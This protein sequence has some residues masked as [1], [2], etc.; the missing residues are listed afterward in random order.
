MSVFNKK[1]W[2][3]ENRLAQ[4]V[5]RKEYARTEKGRRQL[6][7]AARTAWDNEGFR[8]R[9]S[10]QRKD[11][12]ASEKGQSHMKAMN[13]ASQS[14]ASKSLRRSAISK[15]VIGENKSTGETLTFPSIT[16]A[17]MAMNVSIASISDAIK[18]CGSSCGY[19]WRLA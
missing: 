15:K 7:D 12:C 11:Y 16:A 9:K 10:Q 1:Y 17:A 19:L 5:R 4:S 8:K 18:R 3:D 14:E 2:T 13:L 6:S